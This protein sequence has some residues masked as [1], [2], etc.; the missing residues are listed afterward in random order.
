MRLLPF[1]LFF[2]GSLSAQSNYLKNPDIVWAAEIEQDWIIDNPYLEKEW[3]NGITTLKLLRTRKNES[4]RNS[5]YLADLVFEAAANERIQ[6]Y[7][8]PQCSIRTDL[9]SACSYKDTIVTI[10][11]K[12][13]EEKVAIVYSEPQPLYIFKAWRLRQVLAYHKKNATWSTTVEAIAPL[14]IQRNSKGDSVGLRPIFWFRPNDKPQKLSSNNIVWVKE[15]INKED[16]TLVKL[17]QPHMMKVIDGFQNPLVHQLEVLGTN[18]KIPFYGYEAHKLLSPE[19]RKSMLAKNDTIVTFDPETYEE[20][21]VPIQN[22]LNINNIRYLRLTQTWYW[23]ERRHRLSICLNSVA[24]LI[25]VLDS[26]GNFRFARPLYYR[27][28]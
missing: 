18:M 28:K 3:E 23:D 8:D 15:A 26:K 1:L 24:P 6:L 22:E 19:E 2:A 13:H 10:D 21:V 25:D 9:S 5:V 17:D 12:T 11:P 4:Y 16:R 14:I 20:K 7:K 27:R